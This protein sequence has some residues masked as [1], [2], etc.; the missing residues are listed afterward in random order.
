MSVREAVTT[1]CALIALGLA[2]CAP[3]HAIRIPSPPAE[4]RKEAAIP[5]AKPPGKALVPPPPDY[6][7]L[8][9]EAID[10]TKKAIARAKAT[11][12]LPHW[13]RLEDS[14]WRADAI[15]H[16]GVL[17][18][19]AGELDKA[20]DQY[21]RVLSASPSF[22]PAA[23]NLLGIYLLRGEKQKM[24]S[25]TA[26][27]FPPGSDPSL[28]MLPELQANLGSALLETGRQ[29]EAALLFLALKARKP[30]IPSLPWNMAVL[31]YR[32][33]DRDTAKKLAGNLPPEVASL[34]PVV[35]SRVAWTPDRET[36]PVLDTVP[37]SQPR[38]ASLSRNLAAF[39]EYRK[40]NLEAAER[41]L[42]PSV[43]DN[44][45]PAEL[46]S[47]LGILKLEMGKWKE[48]R[49]SL[50]RV[51]TEHP[52]LPEGWLNL[53]IFLEVYEGNPQRA[54]ECYKTYV[55]LNGYRK[56]EVDAWIGWLPES[57]PSSPR[58]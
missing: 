41:H 21:R 49:A 46:I 40:G 47:N 31:A 24:E 15:Y 50:E 19:I 2:A 42:L 45:A 54:R 18:H 32:E 13:K 52:S 53:G 7:K 25:L 26:G 43:T 35:A 6:G 8:Y 14:S 55:K 36:V 5:R 57:S 38:L 44:T 37:A 29:D 27:I 48:A 33:G 1:A 4:V 23:A 16:Q 17:H 22:E 10:Q 34:Y 28:G 58:P 56:Q 20:A 30:R 39:S 11:E 3:R 51:T 9:A 12:A